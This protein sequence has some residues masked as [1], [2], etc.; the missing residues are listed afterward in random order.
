MGQ[1][2]HRLLQFQRQQAGLTLAGI[3]QQHHKTVTGQPA[4]QIVATQVE[5]QQLAEGLQHGIT[6][7]VAVMLVDGREIV[8]IQRQQ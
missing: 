2:L 4:E 8:D 3:G 1:A 5:Q 7:G 6:F